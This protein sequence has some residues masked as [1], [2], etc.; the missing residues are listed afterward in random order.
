MRPYTPRV[1]ERLH[2]E[3]TPAVRT[4]VGDRYVQLRVA[5]G[6]VPH[7][8]PEPGGGDGGRDLRVVFRVDQGVGHQL[9][10]QK[11]GD[12]RTVPVAPVAP[13]V[14]VVLPVPQQ[15]AQSAPYLRNRCE[16]RMPQSAPQMNECPLSLRRCLRRPSRGGTAAARLLPSHSPHPHAGSALS[17]EQVHGMHAPLAR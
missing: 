16:I 8:D 17:L 13:V 14:F 3:E 4:V 1:R 12:V 9:G 7:L 6:E 5:G 2:Q 15:V 10:G 11:L